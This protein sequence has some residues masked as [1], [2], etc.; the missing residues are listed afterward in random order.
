MGAKVRGSA[1]AP[2]VRNDWLVVSI[3][4]G[5]VSVRKKSRFELSLAAGG[6]RP[7]TLFL[8]LVRR[9]MPGMFGILL[10]VEFADEFQFGLREAAWPEIR[11]DLGMSYLLVGLVLG[12]PGVVTG[13]FDLVIGV[14]GDTRHRRRIMVTGGF[15]FGI[16][17]LLAAVSVNGWML[18]AVT[19]LFYPASSAFVSLSQATLMD[20]DPTRHEHNMA[21]W[22][23]AGSVGVVLG[24]LVMAGALSLDISWRWLFAAVGLGSLALTVVFARG[25]S[26]RS[27]AGRSAK[28]RLV[29]LGMAAALKSM[30]QRRVARWLVLLGFS[31]MM[32]DVLLGFLAL[33][34]VDVI[35]VSPAQAAL[36]VTVWSVVGLIGDFAIIPMLERVNGLVYLR[37]SAAL[38]AGVFVAFMFTPWYLAAVVM[39]GVLGFLNAGWYSILQA[40]LYT[41]MPG[42][43][44]RVTAVTSVSGAAGALVP[45]GVGALAAVAGLEVAMWVLLAGPIALMIGVPTGHE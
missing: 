38:T 15:V 7:V 11:N 3:V 4:S 5:V 40:Q 23:F 20:T 13:V 27:G 29:R 8:T 18:L 30:T 21:R 6:L 41:T 34:F 33:Y 28:M 36:A 35:G 24:S 12:V 37:I 43:S 32:L 42:R 1:R 9:M 45:L 44:G 26:A 14:L 31:D 2:P 16:A 25:V 17:V 22:T 19:I 10:A 39:V